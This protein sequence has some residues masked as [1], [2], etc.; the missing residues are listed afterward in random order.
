M[1]I[2]L[3]VSKIRQGLE[4]DPDPEPSG[5]FFD[6]FIILSYPSYKPIAANPILC[7]SV[8]FS[9]SQKR[10]NNWLLDLLESTVTNWNIVNMI[11]Q[12]P[13]CPGQ[14]AIS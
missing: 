10:T 9:T 7:S 8:F 14:V 13:H 12:S 3:L 1:K 5:Y 4:S 2:H 11:E 6:Q